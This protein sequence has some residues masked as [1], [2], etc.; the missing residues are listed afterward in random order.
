MQSIQTLALD[1]LK[2][3]KPFDLY[4]PGPRQIALGVLV[5]KLGPLEMEQCKNALQALTSHPIRPGY[6]GYLKTWKSAARKSSSLVRV[7]DATW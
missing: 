2:L 6:W 7:K 4:I 3:A 5:Q 1:L